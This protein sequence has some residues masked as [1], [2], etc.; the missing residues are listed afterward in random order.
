MTGFFVF[1]VAVGFIF[2]RAFAS[3][4]I[5]YF[6]V[7][8]SLA[9]NVASYWFSD[10]IAL[11]IS[12]AKPA[13]KNEYPELYE[14][15]EK[16][17]RLADIPMPRVYV[18]NDPSPNAFA[19]GRNKNHAAVAAT[20]GIMQVL[21]ESE[22]EGVLAHEI[23]HIKNRDILISS[24]VVVLAGVIAIAS[25]FFLRMTFFR[26]VFG[27]DRDRNE[28]GSGVLMIVGIAAAILAPIAATLIQLAVSRRREFLADESGA[29]LIKNSEP[30]SRALVKIHN[31]PKQLM[32]ASSATAHLYIDN[33]FK[34]KG[35]GNRLVNLFM[36][37]P[38]VEERIKRL[39][40]IL[41]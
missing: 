40:E 38:P 7:A 1:V 13:S 33:P 26:G 17:A 16:T 5:L 24:I 36:T 22:L 12:G 35:G 41:I 2:S 20:T 23:S 6:A 8:L 3:P 10:K 21:S 18:V 11:M 25:D 19:T 15:V 27:G 4:G 32:R 14:A 28:G 37:H 30:L 29:R 39:R 34:R 31:S 9:M